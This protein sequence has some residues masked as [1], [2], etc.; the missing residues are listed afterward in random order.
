MK[1]FNLSDW[2]LGHRSLVWYF[3]IAFM[4]AG[5]F[6]YLQLGRC[7]LNRRFASLAFEAI[8]EPDTK[9]NEDAAW[10]MA[11][12]YDWLVTDPVYED[13]APAATRKSER[14]IVIAADY[15]ALWQSRSERHQQALKR[16]CDANAAL[17]RTNEKLKRA[18]GR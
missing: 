10:E 8:K 1:S 16:L 14:F 12:F 4:A 6:A 15:Y 2:A 17:A 18:C 5:L 11:R 3:M 9:F 7:A 13:F